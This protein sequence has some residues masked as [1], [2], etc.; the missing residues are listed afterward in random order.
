[1]YLDL[2]TSPLSI[3][4]PYGEMGCSLAHLHHHFISS[5]IFC[6]IFTVHGFQLVLFLYKWLWPFPKLK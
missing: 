6:V 3:Q 5:F 1:M 4:V 2:S